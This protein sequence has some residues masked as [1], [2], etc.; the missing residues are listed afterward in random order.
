MIGPLRVGLFRRENIEGDVSVQAMGE[1][2]GRLIF[3]SHSLAN[4]PSRGA[5]A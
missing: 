5:I 4:A 2:F 3:V 1:K